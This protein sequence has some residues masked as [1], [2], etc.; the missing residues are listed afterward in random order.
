MGPEESVSC[1]V[2]PLTPA[3]AGR[4]VSV[5]TVPGVLPGVVRG[6]SC[7]PLTSCRWC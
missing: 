1:V 4:H 7:S 5:H 6:L 3:V 2:L